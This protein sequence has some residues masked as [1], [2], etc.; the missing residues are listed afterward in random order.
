VLEVFEEATSSR[1]AMIARTELVGLSNAANVEAWRQSGVVEGKEWLAV[2]DGN[3]RQEHREL[4]GQ[5]VGLDEP[6]TVDGYRGQHPG[7][8][9]VAALDIQCRCTALPRVSQKSAMG[10][11]QKA[12][13]WKDFDR[14]LSQWEARMVE[15]L[16]RGFRKQEAAVLAAMG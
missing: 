10:E 8:F 12:A 3:T 9:G 1:A 16:Q 5:Q 15:A 11:E 7:G 13:R 4:D 6:F 14:R 2:R